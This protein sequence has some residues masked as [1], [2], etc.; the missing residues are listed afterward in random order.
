[1]SWT[2][3]NIKTT[4]G[5]T[6]VHIN[7]FQARNVFVMSDIWSLTNPKHKYN[8]IDCHC[9]FQNQSEL[10]L[11]FKKMELINHLRYTINSLEN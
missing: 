4:I 1:M 2:N 7:S 11:K 8:V 3:S 9:S 10:G 6:Y 5:S